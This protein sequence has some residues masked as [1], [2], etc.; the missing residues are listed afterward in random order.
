MW[1]IVPADTARTDVDKKSGRGKGI[2]P[3]AWWNMRV[4]QE[5]ANTIIKSAK[6]TFGA[7][8]LLRGVWTGEPEGGA[9]GC[10]EGTDGKIVELLSVVCLQSKNGPP[11][12]CRH[13]GKKYGECRGSIRFATKMK[14]PDKMGKIIQNHEIVKKT[15]ITRN[16]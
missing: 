16:R 6:H 5:S 14:G 15:R 3:E 12:L 4:K 10:K 8:I 7:A 9:M 13:I 11:K 2:R 1:W